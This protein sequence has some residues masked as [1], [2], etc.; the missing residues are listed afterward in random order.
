MIELHNRVKGTIA[1]Y[2]VALKLLS[3][4]FDVFAPLVDIKG[5]DFLIK[6]ENE[7]YEIQVKSSKGDVFKGCNNIKNK[8]NFF[9]IFV[10][11][12]KDEFFTVPSSFVYNALRK[13]ERLDSQG[14]FRLTEQNKKMYGGFNLILKIK[15][16]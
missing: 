12:E 15:M 11:R 13:R 3:L 14:N 16:S 10:N 6:K 5:V 7:L 4:G 9:V 8:N 2:S 1:E